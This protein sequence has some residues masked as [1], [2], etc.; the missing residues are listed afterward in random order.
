MW[1]ISNIR[2]VLVTLTPYLNFE[3]LH[4]SFFCVEIVFSKRSCFASNASLLFFFKR[5]EYIYFFGIL[6]WKCPISKFLDFSV[7]MFLQNILF[8]PLNGCCFGPIFSVRVFINV[9]IF[10]IFFMHF[11]HLYVYFFNVSLWH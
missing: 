1:R 3:I 6:C 11:E 7:L 9:T 2:L 10:I 5:D 4:F 8:L